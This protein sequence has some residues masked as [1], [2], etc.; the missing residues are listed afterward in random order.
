MRCAPASRKSLCTFAKKFL[1]HAHKPFGYFIM[2]YAGVAQR[3]RNGFVNRGLKVRFLSPA[4]I[5]LVKMENRAGTQSA[6]AHYVRY[7]G[8][9]EAG[10]A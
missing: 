2:N 5:K 3:Q 8:P 1:M 6:F 7:G 10:N 4:Y 9:A